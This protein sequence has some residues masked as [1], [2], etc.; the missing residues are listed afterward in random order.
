MRG[1]VDAHRRVSCGRLAAVGTA[2]RDRNELPAPIG[3]RQLGERG[4]CGGAGL[5]AANET[6]TGDC[7]EHPRR[8]QDEMRD[9]ERSARRGQAFADEA[10]DPFGAGEGTFA[11]LWRRIAV[12][13]VARHRANSLAAGPNQRPASNVSSSMICATP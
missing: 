10:V 12:E 4:E 7:F 6:P 1:A 9:V 11:G 8:H 13:R 3:V 2:G 5:V